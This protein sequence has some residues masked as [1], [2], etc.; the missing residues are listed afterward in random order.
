MRRWFKGFL[1]PQ[2]AG[3]VATLTGIVP[4]RFLRA[5]FGG[6]PLIVGVGIVGMVL[7]FLFARVF[8]ARNPVGKGANHHP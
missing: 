5:H 4:A 2:V 7:V 6:A 8:L 3:V 1:R